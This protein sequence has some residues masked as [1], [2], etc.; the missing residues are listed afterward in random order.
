MGWKRYLLRLAG[1]P[2]AALAQ[3]RSPYAGTGQRYADPW[4]AVERRWPAAAS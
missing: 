3:R 2:L 4:G 1:P